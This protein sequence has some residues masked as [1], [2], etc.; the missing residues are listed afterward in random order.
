MQNTF[1]EKAVGTDDKPLAIV[2]DDDKVS[3]FLAI[4]ILETSG[5]RVLSAEDGLEGYEL[6][7]NTPNIAVLVTDNEMPGMGGLAMAKRL[8]DE[9][10]R[11]PKVIMVAGSEISPETLSEHGIDTF[12]G[13]IGLQQVRANLTAAIQGQTATQRIDNQPTP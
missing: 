8:K 11:P 6:V 12:V 4:K 5:F 7:K 1:S 9:G 13:K 10:L 3:S 2:V